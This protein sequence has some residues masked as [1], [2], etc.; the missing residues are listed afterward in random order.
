[1]R[2]YFIE[3]RL[4]FMQHM[5]PWGFIGLRIVF[6]VGI[7][8]LV[9]WLIKRLSSQKTQVVA[10][11]DDN[12]LKIVRERYAKSEITKDEYDVMMKDLA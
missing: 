3:P 8:L 11:K 6:A 7:I 9:V 4:P 5:V 10:S 1:M 2:G 12:A